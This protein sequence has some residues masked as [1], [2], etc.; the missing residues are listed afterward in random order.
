MK[1]RRLMMGFIVTFITALFYSYA[2]AGVSQEEANRLKT[3]LTPMGAERAGNADGTIPEWTGGLKE[4]T[5]G[6]TRNPDDFYQDPFADDKVLFS[7]NARN[8]GKYA[9]KLNPGTIA[10]IKKSPISWKK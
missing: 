4:M 9:D 3:N 6:I 2:G 8:V 7:I 10:M 1:N 5:S